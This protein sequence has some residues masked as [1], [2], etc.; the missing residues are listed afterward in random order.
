MMKTKMVKAKELI[1]NETRDT[2][3]LDAAYEAIGNL[4]GDGYVSKFYKQD[5]EAN[6]W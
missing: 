2:G 4:H 5:Y 1:Y 3:K 6:A